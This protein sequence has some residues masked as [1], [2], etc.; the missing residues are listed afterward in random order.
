VSVR[1][2]EPLDLREPILPARVAL[3]YGPRKSEAVQVLHA[4]GRHARGLAVLHL[5]MLGPLSVHERTQRRVGLVL[6]GH[7]DVAVHALVVSEELHPL[8]PGGIRL[9]APSRAAAGR[10]GGGGMVDDAG[11]TEGVDG[12]PPHESHARQHAY[13]RGRHGARLRRAAV[14]IPVV[15]PRRRRAAAARR[16]LVVTA[17]PLILRA[18]LVT[19]SVQS[20]VVRP[21][22]VAAGYV[23]VSEL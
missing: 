17:H 4:L 12:M 2:A 8:V 14:E 16:P 6:E 22:A 9:G 23:A 3:S 15:A 21:R 11:G 10:G 5:A 20:L 1:I 7:V 18:L 13:P 19:P